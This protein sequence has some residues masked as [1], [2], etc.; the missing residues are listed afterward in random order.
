MTQI[1]D[2]KRQPSDRR[3]S[4]QETA[5]GTSGTESLR[6]APPDLLERF[7]ALCAAFQ[8]EHGIECVC[9]AQPE[10]VRAEPGVADLL[11]ETVGQL[12]ANVARHAARHVEISTLARADGS[13]AV[14]VE[15][16]GA[17]IPLPLTAHDSEA[18][19]LLAIDERLREIGAYI[20]IASV[21]GTCVTVILP[22]RFVVP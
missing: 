4:E 22:G 17:G 8:A 21:P 3:R 13:I 9:R 10:H 1:G 7:E 16:D 5:D 2:A 14:N 15:D 12:L 6:V 19:R 20:E 11:L 18:H